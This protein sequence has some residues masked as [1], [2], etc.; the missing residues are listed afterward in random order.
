M[1]VILTETHEKL[2][3]VGDVVE[4]KPGYAVNF[5][6]PK[7]LAVSATK[8]NLTHWGDKA[9]SLRAKEEKI[10]AARN[11]EKAKLEAQPLIFKA[12]VGKEGRLYGSVTSQNV[13]ELIKEATG[14]EIDK[15]NIVME[16][17]IKEQGSYDVKVKLHPAVQAHVVLK[18]EGED[19]V[20]DS[21]EPE[22]SE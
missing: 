5:L 21:E 8:G 1:K 11:D 22:G 3:L 7:G 20:G 6:I 10:I 16:D 18:I 9:K 2:G 19:T 17:H 14:L 12:N 13:A 4:V 15:K